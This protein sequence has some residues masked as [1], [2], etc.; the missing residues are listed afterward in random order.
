MLYQ[1]F[2]FISSHFF[3]Y[4]FFT[5]ASRLANPP[6]GN[7]PRRHCPTF[8]GSQNVNE[9]SKLQ[10]DPISLEAFPNTDQHSTRFE[11]GLCDF[12]I[13]HHTSMKFYHDSR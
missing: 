11:C 9:M 4:I 12:D 7:E 3:N 5:R 13:F 1:S 10:T 2:I 8:N 6:R